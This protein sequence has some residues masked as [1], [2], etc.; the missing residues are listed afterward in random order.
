M[1]KIIEKLKSFS[2]AFN[3]DQ[4]RICFYPDLT[5]AVQYD[6]YI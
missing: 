3:E 2:P 6:F 5:G 1:E 4:L